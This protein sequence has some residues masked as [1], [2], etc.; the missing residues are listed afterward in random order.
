MKISIFTFESEKTQRLK[1]EIEDKLVAVDAQICHD[2]PDVVITIGGDG[3]VL[4]AIHHYQH[5]LDTVQFIGVHM[6]HLGYYTDWVPDEVDAL[7][8]F[9]KRGEF[10]FSTYQLLRAELTAGSGEAQELY[11]LN[12]F[13][14]LNATRTQHL[15][16]KINDMFLESFRGTGVCVSTPTGSTAYNKSLGGALIYPSISAFQLTEIASINSNAYRTIGSSLIIP[17][18]QTLTLESENWEGMTFTQ[19]H[20]VPEVLDLSAISLSLSDKRV[21]FIKRE[22]GLF[23]K[24]VKDHFI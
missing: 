2:S 1:K 10:E 6:G 19:D 13:T 11:A 22:K 12:E 3:T 20:L 9:I 16:V 23:W 24:R 7:A 18:E 4:K 21:K 17:E 8:A 5:L 14:I 15:N